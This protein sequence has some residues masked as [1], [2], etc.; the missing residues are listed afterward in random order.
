MS[1]HFTVQQLELAKWLLDNAAAP[2]NQGFVAQASVPEA[3]GGSAMQPTYYE[4]AARIASSKAPNHYVLY[5]AE[6][7]AFFFQPRPSAF[8]VFRG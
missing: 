3:Q 8:P 1:S 5:L 2:L 4:L 7:Q 6:Y